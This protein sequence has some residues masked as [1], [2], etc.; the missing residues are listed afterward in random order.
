M[1][2]AIKPDLRFTIRVTR[3]EYSNVTVFKA[4]VSHVVTPEPSRADDD[5]VRHPCSWDAEPLRGVSDLGI[6]AQRDDN[7][8]SSPNFYGWALSYMN[9]H[10]A[11]LRHVE[12][13]VKRLRLT[14]KRMDKLSDRFGQPT[15]LADF[16]AR[17][18]NALGMTDARPFGIWHDDI[19][20]NGTHY[21]WVD[22]DGLRSWLDKVTTA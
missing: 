17:A 10:T 19:T 3:N 2:E 1:P 13:M 14:T 7:D 12:A 21:R 15:D 4:F 6:Y 11:T 5:G 20:I 8:T 9:V 22:V 16:C 18:A